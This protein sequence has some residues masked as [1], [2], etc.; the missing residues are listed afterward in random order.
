MY[1]QEVPHLCDRLMT[2]S[3]IIIE[4]MIHTSTFM[5]KNIQIQSIM[6]KGMK[7][8]RSDTIYFAHFH[9]FVE[10]SDLHFIFLD[11]SV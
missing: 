6:L 8:E 3:H 4:N 7:Y 1:I 11:F 10:E 5:K 2:V 9:A